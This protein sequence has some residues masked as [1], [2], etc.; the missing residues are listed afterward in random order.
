[1]AVREGC[2]CP[3]CRRAR[4][5]YWA[6][7]DRR[8]REANDRASTLLRGYLTP[9]QLQDW[10]ATGAFNVRGADHKLYRVNGASTRHDA[11]VRED[12]WGT[13]VWLRGIANG[14]PADNALGLMLYLLNEPGRVVDSGCHDNIRVSS[15]RPTDYSGAI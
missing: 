14:I 3:E 15:A 6:E 11:V 13:S 10:L 12:G 7:Q 2:D 8:D 1:V 4:P 5:E 9:E